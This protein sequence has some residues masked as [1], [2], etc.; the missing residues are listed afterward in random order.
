MSSEERRAH[1]ETLFRELN[2][3][4]KEIDERLDPH[5]I[6]PPNSELQLLCEC[7]DVECATRFMMIP[8]DYE[9]L[10]E[11][12]SHFAVIPGHVDEEIEHVVELRP[13]YV[14]VSKDGA[15]AEIAHDTDPRDT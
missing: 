2:E 6:G 10:R 5:G 13:G 11:Q 7:S 8:S 9:A 15:A 3:R 1:N 14:I 4:L 12:A